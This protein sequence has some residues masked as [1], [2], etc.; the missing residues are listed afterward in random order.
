MVD[1][2]RDLFTAGGISAVIMSIYQDAEATT[3]L[4][5]SDGCRIVGLPVYKTVL[6]PT[7]ESSEGTTI[8]GNITISFNG[9][10]DFVTLD[11]GSSAWYVLA[12]KPY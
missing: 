4:I 10:S 7:V 3:P 1:S 2:I 9:G 5:D 12:G 11:Q 8:P 6:T